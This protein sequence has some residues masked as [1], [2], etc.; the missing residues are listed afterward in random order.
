MLSESDDLLPIRLVE[1][2]AYCPRQAWYRFVALR[3]YTICTACVRGIRAYGGEPTE[4]T[5]VF[6]G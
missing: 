4:D 5:I 2:Y 3:S 1:S 6:F